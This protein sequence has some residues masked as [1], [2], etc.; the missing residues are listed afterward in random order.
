MKKKTR[1]KFSESTKKGAVDAYRS[2]T[3]SAQQIASE[4]NVEVQAIYRWKTTLEEKAKGNRIE[5][6]LDGGMS[7]EVANRMLLMEAEIE[8]YQKKVAE[9]TII[10]DLLKKLRSQGPL[11]PESELSGLIATTLKL[12][13]KRKLVR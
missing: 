7:T 2:G 11:P 9:L 12:A 1:R 5:E 6:L 4:L 8:A 13:R 3:K 10:N